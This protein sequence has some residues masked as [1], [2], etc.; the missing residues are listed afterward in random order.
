MNT[1]AEFNMPERKF[2]LLTWAWFASAAGGNALLS[3]V[4]RLTVERDAALLREKD[5]RGTVVSLVEQVDAG[6]RKMEKMKTAHEKEVARL[7]GKIKTKA[8]K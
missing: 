6:D 3:Q 4:R 8:K 5:A 1:D 7:M 2:D